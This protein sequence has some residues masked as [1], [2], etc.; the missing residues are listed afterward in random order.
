MRSPWCASSPWSHPITLVNNLN[1]YTTRG[2]EDGEAFEVV[3]ELGDAPD[4]LC[5]P[6]GNGGNIAAYWRGFRDSLQR[7]DAGDATAPARLS[8]RRRGAARE[9]QP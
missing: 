1:P 8:G 3:D 6:V 7:G 9:R 5:L 2:S 4:W